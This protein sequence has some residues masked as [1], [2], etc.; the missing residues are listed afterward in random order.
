MAKVL[1][2]NINKTTIGLDN[3][4]IEEVD[5]ASLDFIPQVDDELEVYKTGDEIIVR[6]CNKEQFYHNGRRVNKLVYALL[7]IFLGSFGIHKFYAGL[8]FISCSF[9]LV[10]LGL[11]ALLRVLQHWSRK[12]TVMVISIYRNGD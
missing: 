11:L 7:A 12:L 5:T 3:G 9:G 1:K 10:Y 2:T 4:S 6:K 8:L